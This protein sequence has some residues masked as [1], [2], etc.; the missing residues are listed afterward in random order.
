MI[1]I[2]K[3]VYAEPV[4]SSLSALVNIILAAPTV[5]RFVYH[6]RPVRDALGVQNGSPHTNVI[7]MRVE[8]SALIIVGGLYTILCFVPVSP[9]GAKFMFDIIAHNYVGGLKLN[10][11]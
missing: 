10:D 2:G 8:F 3:L 7:A 5:F 11:F 4:F 1:P 6:R 9:Y